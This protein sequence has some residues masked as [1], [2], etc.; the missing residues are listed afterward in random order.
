[1][2]R[3]F[4]LALGLA[5]CSAAK[6]GNG[7]GGQASGNHAGSGGNT[8]QQAGSGGDGTFGNPTG[9]GG[10]NALPLDAGRIAIDGGNCNQD[11]D[12]VFV[13][14][15]SGSMIP[16]LTKLVS[17]VDKVDAALK[18]KHLPGPPH[19]GLVIFVDDVIVLNNGMAYATL[20][21]AKAAIN[22]EIAT[23]NT[24][25]GRQAAPGGAFNNDWPENAIDGLYAA[26]TGFQWRDTATTLRTVIL[27][28]DASFR[29]LTK[30]SSA[31]GDPMMLETGNG[32]I[33]SMHSYDET[34]AAL[35]D[36]SIWVNTFTAKTGGPPTLNPSPPSHGAFRG[37]DVNV[38]IGYFEPYD[39]RNAIAESTGGLAW[40]I[41]DVFDGKISLAT[42]I[43]QAVEDRQ[44]VSYPPPPPPPE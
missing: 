32:T 37:V 31:A 28:T 40:D 42:P 15:V 43:N 14:D 23:T 26:A 33:T 44:C 2:L 29:D 22:N 1:M 35:R 7:H 36:H 11:V 41:D 16:P 6:S 19:Y 5:A 8:T 4:A 20:D 13:L 18:A 39:G 17:E 34:I 24:N 27:I 3:V 25:P 21:D 9:N 10:M 12:I 30:V 38:G